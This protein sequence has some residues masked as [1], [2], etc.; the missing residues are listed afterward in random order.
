MTDCQSMSREQH[1]LAKELFLELCTL[2]RDEQMARL[3]ELDGE[4]AVLA[5]VRDLLGF[6]EE[7][8]ADELNPQISDPPPSADY[9]SGL[10]ESMSI[11]LSPGR[12]VA[13]R[14]RI[15]RP[16]GQGGMGAIYEAEDLTLGARV[17]LKFLLQSTHT[18][19]LLNEARAARQVTH[20]N[21]CRVFDF[22]EVDDMPF[23]SMEYVD[24]EDLRSLL[25]RIGR[26]PRD[27]TVIIAR[28]MFAGLAAAHAKGVLHRDLK[29]ANIMID[30]RGEVRITDFGIALDSR[31]RGQVSSS[32]GTPAFM[33]PEV[34]DGGR[35][36]EKSDLY[37]MGLLL[38]EMCTGAYPFE[39]KGSAEHRTARYS[40]TPAPPSSLV[41]DMDPLLERVILNC[42]EP[43]PDDRPSSALAVAA[44]L[45]GNDDPLNLAVSIGETPSP[46]MVADAGSRD[47]MSPRLVVGLAALAALF[48][49][50]T[51]WIS[52][53]ARQLDQADLSLPPE[54]L[55]EKAREHLRTLGW[56]DEP[57]D[58]A[59]GY[60][61]N[62]FAL[63]T[64]P[65]DGE[66]DAERDLGAPGT[67]PI[68]FWYRQ[69]EYAMVPGSLPN[70]LIF[71]AEVSP[72]DPPIDSPGM[73]LVL[74]HPNGNLDHLEVYP[75]L[76]ESQEDRAVL[77][78][79]IPAADYGP[80]LRAAG[81]DPA[82]MD[83]EPA[84]FAP[85]FYADHRSAF[86]GAS[87]KRPD[88]ALNVR[89]ASYMGRTVFFRLMPQV[90]DDEEVQASWLLNLIDEWN[91]LWDLI[92]IISILA[93]IPIMRRNLRRGRGDRRAAQ[94]V[95]TFV[96]VISTLLWIL[97][98][99]HV[100]DVGTQ[101]LLTQMHV[102]WALVQAGLVWLFYLAF[103][104]YVRRIWPQILVAWTRL[105]SGRFS[106]PL[107]GSSVLVGIVF[108][109]LMGLL[110]DLDSV[111]PL[112][113]GLD[114]PPRTI[115]WL[116]LDYSLHA[117]K[118]LAAFGDNII[119]A[120][121]S[122]IFS[123][124]ILVLLRLVLPRPW[125]A[126]LAYVGLV[127]LLYA[128]DGTHPSTSW[129]TAG[130][131]VAGLEV[132]MLTRFG[133]VTLT[134]ATFCSDTLAAF[135]LTLDMSIWYADTSL[136]AFSLL[137]AITA[138]AVRSALQP[139]HP[140]GRLTQHSYSSSSY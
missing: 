49:F 104:P 6:Y 20:R 100:Q 114:V 105:V 33:A 51:A 118:S 19:H 107:V 77:G 134:V 43:A 69:S 113:L 7:P 31:N 136:L 25:K 70:L 86:S 16:L 13:E 2:E 74:M 119:G 46:D 22:G 110:S 10:L 21:V 37:A 93:C 32:A 26:L 34:L 116:Q 138:W 56:T 38:Y 140:M 85:P 66:A 96:F 27:R 59:Y 79:E 87:E 139:H 64:Y 1:L 35:P 111:L 133:L 4:P 42:L 78:D 67:S 84:F 98:G 126:A 135:P 132:W 92:L 28:Q 82:Q 120:I 65:T 61:E 71:N 128:H 91:E 12:V 14:Y 29:P 124:M 80:V 11:K 131:A 52:V 101:W 117:G 106:D 123:L 3:E 137:A 40:Q 83:S 41:E 39:A 47:G 15:I 36:S 94:R 90:N 76:M 48:T 125:A 18:R 103:E 17:A 54:V 81:L 122:S 109:T 23:I 129:L 75:R 44:A 115:N 24:G 99:A 9:A 53:P 97:S 5:E 30:G 89:T 60:L 62:S 55:A 50:L 68:L 45:P 88:L 73:A 8:E 95:A 121:F 108:G 127:A 130:L 57:A 102:G 63:G 58:S 112:W 72:Y